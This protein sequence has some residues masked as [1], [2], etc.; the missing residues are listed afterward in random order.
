MSYNI[1]R[2]KDGYGQSLVNIFHMD[3]FENEPA[4]LKKHFFGMVYSVGDINK[5]TV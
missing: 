3:K 5:Y 4:P 1:F 2:G